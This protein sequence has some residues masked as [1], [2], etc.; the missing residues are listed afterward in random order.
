LESAVEGSFWL[1]VDGVRLPRACA[2]H[3]ALDFVNTYAGWDEPVGGDYLETYDH[4]VVWTSLSGL[5]DARS[6][7]ALRRRAA[8][9]KAE[10]AAVLADAKR[11]RSDLRRAALH[12]GHPKAVTAVSQ[13]VER[14]AAKAF[15]EPGGFGGAPHW[16][17]GGGL[18][19]P[20]L[21]VAW[22]A[23]DLLTQVD[24]GAVGSC[25]GPGCG[26]MFLDPRGRRRWC[27][28]QWCGNRAKVRAHA[29]RQRA[30]V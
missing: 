10:A 17:V 18:E 21:V 19:R 7:T 23:A 30:A 16:S 5:I 3:P 15:L 6:A 27:S 14:A 24:L 26:W 13:F 28:M 1:E 12:P 29:E 22:S 25:P 11:L 9:R 4:L 8:A 20:L 2:G